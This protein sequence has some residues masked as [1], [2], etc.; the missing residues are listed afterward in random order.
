MYL[1]VADL[2]TFYDLPLGRLLRVLIGGRV[3]T[4][5]P[6]LEGQSLLGI[7]YAGP[8]MRPYLGSAERCIAAMPAQQGAVGWPREADNAATLVEDSRL[9][10][11]DAYFDRVMVVHALDHAADPSA[12][13]REAW[14]VL[15][16]GGRL[17]AIVPNRRGLWAQ[18][19]LSPF[20]YGRPYS[21][22]QLRNLLKSCQFDVIGQ[23]EALFLPPSRLRFVL[24]SARTW[25]GLGRRLWPAFSGLLIMEAEKKVYRGIPVEGSRS[26]LRVLRPVFIPDG[27]PAGFKPMRYDNPDEV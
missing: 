18:S 12:I 10:F 21:R 16:P 25:E 11:S 23:E 22:G 1:D 13:L 15:A 24:R 14:R 8:F 4:L 6:S 19:E 5:W 9:P 7:G 27:A 17:I 2:R 3:R 26:A 20:G